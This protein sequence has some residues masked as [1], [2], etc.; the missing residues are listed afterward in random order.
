VRL[1]VIGLPHTETTTEFV[2]CAYTQK[3]VKFGKMMTALGHEVIVYS[4]EVN[5]TLCA[6]HVPVVSRDERVRWFGEHDQN[7]VWGNV[8]WD[9]T[10]EPWVVMNGRVIGEIRKRQ[11][12]GDEIVCLP[13]GTP[14]M[15]VKDTLSD[16]VV[17]EPFV[18]YEGITADYCA[19]ESHAWRH[20]VYGFF[21]IGDGRWY[22][23]VIPNYFD[24]DDFPHEPVRGDYLLFVGRVTGR[25]NPQVA[26]Q[27]A[28]AAGMKL[29]VAGPGVR[30]IRMGVNGNA[31]QV[32]GDGCVLIGD[33]V[34]YV[35][36]VDVEQRAALMANAAALIAPT[37]FIEPFGGV[38]VEAMM[39]GTPV[40]T[41]PWGAFTETVEEGVSGYRFNTLREGV[42]AVG[43][44]LELDPATVRD[45]ALSR[46]AL[47][48]V[49]RRFGTWFD[50]LNGLVTGDDWR[51][52]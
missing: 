45:Y 49:G 26:A 23:D 37:A 29:V 3:L 44:A 50:R 5:E 35:G 21:K 14:C 36:P 4:G 39:A 1:H 17:C 31:P 9:S 18:G 7:G 8:T 16:M 28:E 12:G 19:F 25:K 20:Y 48:P 46:Y 22:D 32:E 34:D 43:R 30:H 27:I 33:H 47:D 38:A 13:T 40:V 41:S 6:E 52:V 11:Q 51:A 15:V 2:T 42:R 10:K 24:P